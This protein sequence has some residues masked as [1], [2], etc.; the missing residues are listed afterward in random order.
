MGV[1]MDLETVSQAERLAPDDVTKVEI[2]ES[3]I[4]QRVIDVI[5]DMADAI[6][7]VLTKYKVT[8]AEYDLFRQFHTVL[9]PFMTGIW[10]PWIS[11][12]MER[13]NGGQSGTSENPEGPFY[14]ADAPTLEPPHW[15]A[16]EGAG[17][18]GTPLIVRGQVRSVDGDP[19][20]GAEFD[21]W[22]AN[23]DGFYSSLGQSPTIEDGDF[24]GKFL[25]DADG[26]YEFRTIKPPPYRSVFVIP[27]IDRFF[28]ALGRSNYRPSHIHVLLTHPALKE[29]FLTQIYFADDPYRDYDIGAAVRDDLI[30]TPVLHDDPEEIKAAGYD[31]PFL[32]VDFDFALQVTQPALV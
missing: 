15:L 23:F 1:G 21:L 13:I 5:G 3:L 8:Y 14:V 4:D 7:G 9:G 32:T 27:L 22:Q 2:D 12:M 28:E 25:T 10:D 24:R 18:K 29:K 20:A 16:K 19:L 11:P 17:A 30:S 6:E 31:R 26:R